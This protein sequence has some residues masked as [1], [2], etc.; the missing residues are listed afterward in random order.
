MKMLEIPKY[1]QIGSKHLVFNEQL[2]Y[3]EWQVHLLR[4]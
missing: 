2:G 1:E 3:Y 4:M